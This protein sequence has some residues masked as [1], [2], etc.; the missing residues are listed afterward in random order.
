M[1]DL[2][3]T[4]HILVFLLFGLVVGVLARIIVPGKEPG[5]WV[6]SMMLGVGG[7]VLGGYFGRVLGLYREGQPAGFLMALV[8]AIALVA[9][10]HAVTSGRRWA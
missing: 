4:M 7:A 8:G 9:V 10:Y 1:L 5:G 6:V 2:E 3:V